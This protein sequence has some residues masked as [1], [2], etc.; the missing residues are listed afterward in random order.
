M[1]KDELC[2]CSFIHPSVVSSPSKPSSCR[3]SRRYSS[4]TSVS[5][6][7]ALRQSGC[8]YPCRSWTSSRLAPGLS[9]SGVCSSRTPGRMVQKCS[10]RKKYRGSVVN[11]EPSQDVHITRAVKVGKVAVRKAGGDY[12][13]A[14]WHRFLRFPHAIDIAVA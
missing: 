14:N 8:S 10:R 7:P 6:G 12:H 4:R 11:Q 1:R 3:L 5:R 13:T 9:S 2:S